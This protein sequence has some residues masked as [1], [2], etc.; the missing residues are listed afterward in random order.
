MIAATQCYWLIL[1][2]WSRDGL[3]CVGLVAV[4]VFLATWFR[5]PARQCP[6]CKEINRPHAGY[7]AQ[8]GA[9]LGKQK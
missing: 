2:A 9:P 3:V 8:C 4:F 6:R 1:G 5:R 7:C